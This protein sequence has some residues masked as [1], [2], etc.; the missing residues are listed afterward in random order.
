MVLF[1]VYFKLPGEKMWAHI[2]VCLHGCTC[3]IMVVP[4]CFVLSLLIVS[5]ARIC[6][7][8]YQKK[9]ITESV[10][11]YLWVD[12]LEGWLDQLVYKCDWLIDWLIGGG[13]NGL[14][15]R[16]TDWLISQSDWLTDWLVDWLIG[17]LTDL[18]TDWLV[19]WLIGWLSGWSIGWLIGWLT[20]WLIGWLI[21][22]LTGWLIEWLIGWLTGWLVPWTENLPEAAAV[23]GSLAGHDGGDGG[24]GACRLLQCLPCAAQRQR[25]SHPSR[26][27][28]STSHT[29]LG[30]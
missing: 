12:E 5:S 14:T 27:V 2:H 3:T 4:Y 6:S 28:V 21:G 17:W 25:L 8:Y 30:Q 9:T 19:N 20:G 10:E 24:P 23:P 16:V 11:V 26:S 1:I 29:L 13:M 7:S 18:L 15:D 22:W